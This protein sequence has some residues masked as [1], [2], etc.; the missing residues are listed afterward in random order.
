MQLASDA[1]KEFLNDVNT[2]APAWTQTV[3]DSLS[4]ITL[5]CLLEIREE[6]SQMR[7]KNNGEVLGKVENHA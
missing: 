7:K 5:L 3:R 2:R 6:L 4:F 1:F